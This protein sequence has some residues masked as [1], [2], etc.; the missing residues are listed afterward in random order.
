VVSQVW[1]S[2]VHAVIV[3]GK[4]CAAPCVSTESTPHAQP[5][6]QSPGVPDTAQNREQLPFMR[7]DLLAAQLGQVTR[8]RQLLTAGPHHPSARGRQLL[9]TTDAVATIVPP[10]AP[11]TPETPL[12]VRELFAG[13]HRVVSGG[14]FHPRDPEQRGDARQ[15]AGDGGS[16]R[17]EPPDERIEPVAIH[18][19]LLVWSG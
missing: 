10:S 2:S 17:A 19:S 12:G 18:G 8:F 14:L 15:P 7:Q 3:A 6:G 1:E 11:Q 13:W 5:G 9:G 4:Q 16:A